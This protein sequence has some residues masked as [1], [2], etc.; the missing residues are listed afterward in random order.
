MS[1]FKGLRKEKTGKAADA[2]GDRR[3]FLKGGATAAAAATAVA[4]FP[5]VSRAQTATLKMQTSWG[6]TSPFQEMAK[7][8]VDR[9][10]AM[11]GGRLKI[12]LL[13]AGSVV[14]A[15]QV[16][17]ACHSGVLDATHTVTAYWYSKNKAASLFGTG[18]VLAPT[19]RRYWPGSTTAAARSC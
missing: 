5:Q 14:K 7:Q 2:G 17:D 19:P 3:R 8:Y 4:A 12:D 16:Q 11:A 13:P 1:K 10:E 6:A 9:V 18:P 15:F